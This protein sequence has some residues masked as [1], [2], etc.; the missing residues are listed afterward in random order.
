MISRLARGGMADVYKARRASDK[1]EVAVKVM[2]TTV[3]SDEEFKRLMS[4]F[5]QEARI[6]AEMRHPHIL[7]VYD[8]G[9]ER[10]YP[11]FSMKLV[12]GGTLA[13]ILRKGQLPLE[14]VGGWLHQIASALDYA[15]VK[16]VIHRDL[17]PTNILL[18]KEGNAYLT[19]FGIAKLA[20]QTSSFTVTGNVLGTPTYMAPEQ[21]RSEELSPLTDIYGLGILAYL[22]LTGK[23]P[24]TADTPHSLMYK[25]L[26]DPPPP[27]KALN[28]NV[29]EQIEWV[30]F[31]ALAKRPR[32]RYGR[33]SEFS[34]DYQRA[35]RGQE[36]WAARER[37]DVT[38]PGVARSQPQQANSTPPSGQS[39]Q[40]QRQPAP[41]APL[42][43][44]IYGPYPQPNTTQSPG[45][46]MSHSQPVRAV[47]LRPRR[48]RRIYWTAC[49]GIL[50][51][52]AVAVGLGIF[53]WQAPD[54]W[55]PVSLDLS[56]DNEEVAAPTPTITP[57][58]SPLPGQQPDIIINFPANGSV[59][60]VDDEVVISVTATDV[61]GVTRL[62]VRRFG[63]VIDT[64]TPENGNP[65]TSLTTNITY[66][67][68]QPGRHVIEVIPYRGT[69]RGDSAILD[70]MAQ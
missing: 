31:K 39:P 58:P 40:A 68:R 42:P 38:Q 26:N 53:I 37:I 8:Y 67:P 65:L 20:T 16:K 50:F 2:R 66:T 19:D 3:E 56:G 49:A 22:M 62:E 32:D 63:F 51:M 64:I 70:F 11:Y 27:M 17:K 36:T 1:Q 55:L 4:R 57:S 29:T 30:I 14:H 46:S 69:I 13:D 54:D 24:F 25:H 10:G 28:E 23:P 52:I 47:H 35:L 48:R 6:V 60:P 5:E 18:D 59:F 33:A 44:P 7:P 43:P 21:W 9:S 45:Y 15:H 12:E 61:Q 34:H 41:S